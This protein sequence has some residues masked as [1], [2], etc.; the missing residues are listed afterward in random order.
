MGN[1][2]RTP[3]ASSFQDR[4]K[5]RD[6]EKQLRE[7][8]EHSK[9]DAAGSAASATSTATGGAGTTLWNRLKAAKEVINATITGE[10]KWPES[11]DSDY[12]GESHVT[13]V[14]REYADKKEDEEMAA[15]IAELDMMPTSGPGSKTAGA[16]SMSRNQYL[17]DAVRKEPS[18]PSIIST[19]SSNEQEDYYG[20]S[21]RARGESTSKADPPERS[22]SPASASVSTNNSSNSYGSNNLTVAS[23]TRNRYRTTSDASRDDALSRLE[24]KSEGD[25]LAAHVNNLGSTSP[26]ARANSPSAGHRHQEP[27]SSSSSYQ[28][29][30]QSRNQYQQYSNQLSPSSAANP[31]SYSSSSSQRS[32]SPG[33]NRRY[34]PPSP[35]GPGRYGAGQPQP[36][37]SP[38]YPSSNNSSYRQQ[39]PPSPSHGDAYGS[40]GRAGGDPSQ[41]RGRPE[42]DRRPTYP[43]QT[44]GGNGYVQASSG[45]K[46]LGAY[47]QRQQQ[48]QH[49]QHQPYQQ[50]QQSYGGNQGN[51]F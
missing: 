17:R 43:P 18:T 33:A 39:A 41:G 13:R 2:S 29:Q 30:Q 1:G 19:T 45:G 25:K 27:A 48:Q 24:G 35:S 36:P 23:A 15:K 50:Y 3:T 32:V 12:E 4:M 37:V 49:Q 28:Q 40:R 26:R 10:E 7:R 9:G 8:E 16:G 46:N 31:N 51:Y 42:Y 44:S 20:K 5:E 34:D 14:L 38:S 22:W 21:L 47:G 6:R 11:D